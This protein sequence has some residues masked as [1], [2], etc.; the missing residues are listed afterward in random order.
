MKLFDWQA[1]FFIHK[2][3]FIVIGVLF[4]IMLLSIIFQEAPS[5]QN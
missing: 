2:G 1:E 5:P 3:P 4:V